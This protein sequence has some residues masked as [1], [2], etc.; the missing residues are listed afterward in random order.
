MAKVDVKMP[1]MGESITEGTVIVWHKKPG[2]RIALDEPLLEI[3]TDKVDTEVPAS[4]AGVLHTILV[5]EGATVEVGSVLAI[6]ETEV[7][8]AGASSSA[9]QAPAQ[10]QAPAPE[11]AVAAPQAPAPGKAPAIPR[12]PAQEKAAAPAPVQAASVRGGKVPVIMPKMGESITEGTII[13]WRKKPGDVI[14]L[15]EPLLEIGTDKVDTEVP[16]AAAGVLD[17]ILVAEGETVAVGTLLAIILT[18][19]GAPAEAPAPSAGSPNAAP[20]KASSPGASAS[21]NGAQ[22]SATPSSP[23]SPIEEATESRFLSPLVRS[24]AEKEGLSAGELAG[25][26]GSGREG[27]ITKQDILAHL[28]TRGEAPAVAPTPSPA[29]APARVVA[30][31]RKEADF[32]GRVEIVEMDR[33]RQIIAEHMVRSKATSAHVT[34]F[35]EADVTNLVRLR[36]IN[37]EAFQ[38][39]E[40][41]KLTF[42][43]FM[44]KAAVEALR[45]HPILNASVDGTRILIKKDYHIGIAVAIDASRLVVPVIRDAGQ[46]NLAGLAHAAN[47]LATRARSKRLQPDDLQ[48]GT[49][50]VTN[51]GSVGSVMG[52]PI[53]NQPQVAILATGAIKKRPVVIEDPTLGDVIAIRHMM[54][55]SLS[56]DHRVIDGAMAA[57]F[58]RRYV[59]LLEGF[60]P[61]MPL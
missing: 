24:I 57:S 60:L 19:A 39:R 13:A 27:R 7:D 15:D 53:I 10:A 32:G 36:D 55:I 9:P 26:S 40:G 41:V 61:T 21:D 59:G 8:A 47:D 48:G 50:T 25:I 16:A 34:S 37:K 49:F 1:K 56:Y 20:P 43:P 5:E 17:R 44:V 38:T 42:T 6:I 52:T 18:G 33:M 23:A 12:A 2:D 46:K 4:A 51:I 22:P 3:G 11:K 31:V 45:E 14:E 35:A 58:L 54:Y 29:S 30:P 28:A